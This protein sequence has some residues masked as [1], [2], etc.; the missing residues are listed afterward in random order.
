MKF[1]Y[2]ETNNP[3]LCAPCPWVSFGSPKASLLS[4]LLRTAVTSLC[5]EV[6]D[7]FA[8][9]LMLAMA[10]DIK[11][12]SPNVQCVVHVVGTMSFYD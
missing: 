6:A 7:D 8:K 1:K 12:T 10:L 2:H 11:V 4:R 9:L 3:I 5:A